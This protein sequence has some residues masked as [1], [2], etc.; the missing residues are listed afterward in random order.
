MTR[1]I[2]KNCGGC[3]FAVLIATIF[4]ICCRWGS[5]P[6]ASEEAPGR[7]VIIPRSSSANAFRFLAL[8]FGPTG[9]LRRLPA[10]AASDE[11]AGAAGPAD[12]QFYP[13]GETSQITVYYKPRPNET[14][15][16]VL[17][18]SVFLDMPSA[19]GS[20]SPPEY[21]STTASFP[22]GTEISCL[23]VGEDVFIEDVWCSEQ[24]RKIHLQH[25]VYEFRNF[26]NRDLDGE[27]WCITRRQTWD[28]SGKVTCQAWYDDRGNYHWQE[29]GQDGI[30]REFIADGRD[31]SESDFIPGQDKP[32]REFLYGGL[33]TVLWLNDQSGKHVVSYTY[34]H[35][36][37]KSDPPISPDVSQIVRTVWV[38]GKPAYDQLF[39]WNPT[40]KAG[41]DSK[42]PVYVFRGT[43]PL[44]RVGKKYLFVRVYEG[45]TRLQMV[46]LS[47]SRR[48]TEAMGPAYPFACL[49]EYEEEL[50][51]SS[52]AAGRGEP[53][54]D[55]MVWTYR[56]DD[57]SLRFVVFF[58]EWGD[59]KNLTASGKDLPA[60][61][62]ELDPDLPPDFFVKDDMKQFWVIP[63]NMTLELDKLKPVP[64][65]QV[66]GCPKI[67]PHWLATEDLPPEPHKPEL[68]PY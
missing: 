26:L 51:K 47:S 4:A 44:E 68:L 54:L 1:T 30:W 23:R 40:S 41:A 56:R 49:P 20:S 13:D 17:I 8:G 24:G 16:R 33:H 59:L 39:D 31:L 55:K 14:K 42:K 5:E 38:D 10:Q 46:A 58:N 12:W 66:S 2:L 35:P 11:W 27:G 21:S 28:K 22:D 52:Y 48:Y 19:P 9:F 43:T 61:R 50:K 57:G 45:T 67:D 7:L 6:T 32:F 65:D 60:A 34:R 25:S 37:V 62:Q 63:V 29:L 15:P 36:I 18:H 3:F 53:P 64:S